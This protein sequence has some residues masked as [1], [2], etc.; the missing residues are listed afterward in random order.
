MP[1]ISRSSPT[2]WIFVQAAKIEI[3]LSHFHSHKL[4]L[5]LG[6]NPIKLLINTFRI[7]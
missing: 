4:Y 1:V 5:N 3:Q 2:F 7:L 6:Q